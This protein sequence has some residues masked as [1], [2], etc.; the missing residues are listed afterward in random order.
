M[1]AKT[2]RK[3]TAAIIKILPDATTVTASVPD[4]AGGV[5]FWQLDLSS[6]KF[7]ARLYRKQVESAA[8]GG[9]K[10]IDTPAPES[11]ENPADRARIKNRLRMREVR[12]KK[13]LE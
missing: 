2:K 13:Q 4:G 8:Q 10:P 11:V 7:F 1:D 3:Q 9:R 6:V 12:K 5:E